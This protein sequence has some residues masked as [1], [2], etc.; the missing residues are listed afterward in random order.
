MRNISSNN[1]NCVPIVINENTNNFNKVVCVYVTKDNDTNYFYIGSNISLYNKIK[2]CLINYRK[3]KR[4]RNSI[5]H[6]YVKWCED[7]NKFSLF[8]LKETPNYLFLYIKNYPNNK[9]TIEEVNLL[10]ILSLFF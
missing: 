8:I 6:T 10:N 4:G 2:S 9:L 5:F 1:N 7:W 3:I